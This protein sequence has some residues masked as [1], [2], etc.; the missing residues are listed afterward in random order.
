MVISLVQ[1]ASWCFKGLSWQVHSGEG[2]LYSPPQKWNRVKVV[3]QGLSYV[4]RRAL[5]TLAL[6]VWFLACLQMLLNSKDHEKMR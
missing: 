3:Q 2:V 5:S 6:W 4:L 1:M